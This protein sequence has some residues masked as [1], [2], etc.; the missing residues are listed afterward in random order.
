M[1]S[2]KAIEAPETEENAGASGPTELKRARLF[3]TDAFGERPHRMRSR[4]LSAGAACLPLFLLLIYPCLCAD[5]Q[6]L[7]K[8]TPGS[9]Q[10]PS[11]AAVTRDFMDDIPFAKHVI[12]LG[13]AETCAVGD[14]NGDGKL[15]VI[16]GGNWYEGL[17]FQKNRFRRLGYENNNLDDFSVHVLDVNGD[18]RLDVISSTWFS[19]KISWFENPGKSGGMWKEHLIDSGSPVEFSFL[20]DLDNDGKAQE[21][22][23]QFGG[24]QSQ[25][26]WYGLENG[27]YV[28]HIVS[29]AGF[30][31]GI[32]AGD[33]NGDGRNDILTPT[34]WWEAP[35][36][37]RKGQWTYHKE[38]EEFKFTRLGFMHVLDINGDGKNDVLTSYAHERGLFWLERTADGKWTKHIIDE[39]WS[40]PHAVTIADLN[41][42]GQMEVVTGKRYHAHNGK[43]LGGN[44]PLGLYWYDYTRNDK[45]ELVW[46]RHILEYGGRVGGGMQVRVVDIDRDGDLDIAVAGKGGLYWFENLSKH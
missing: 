42:D 16:S 7:T 30:G 33:V 11:G 3:R 43:D 4:F 44:E 15:D 12:D 25:L 27:S 23:P 38:F 31:H 46:M 28:K 2:W 34:G 39:S 18:G 36:D 20:V 21:L 32:G 13:V 19:R 9:R 35:P 45:G 5:A 40:Q 24:K 22:L 6:G 10:N 37:P 17:G 26:V 14:V 41:N 8:K 1:S 29:D